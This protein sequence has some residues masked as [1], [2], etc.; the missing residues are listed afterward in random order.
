MQMAG[1]PRGR[2]RYRR[3]AVEEAPSHSAH[4]LERRHGAQPLQR[5]LWRAGRPHR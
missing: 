5:R 1:L 4:R 2:D 3:A